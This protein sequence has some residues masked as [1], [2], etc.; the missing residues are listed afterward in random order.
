M[1][2]QN[3]L[4]IRL[5]E[6]M[7]RDSL[8]QDELGERLK[9]SQ[10]AISGLLRTV[11][12]TPKNLKSIC[13]RL[14]ADDGLDVLIGHLHD[15]IE[16]AGRSHSELSIRTTG[17]QCADE[18]QSDLDYLQSRIHEKPVAEAVSLISGLIRGDWMKKYYP[19]K[20]Q[21]PFGNA[22]ETKD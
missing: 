14:A 1:K 19:S 3:Q 17:A 4:G 20:T 9:L 10:G 15:E 13:T 5:A 8:R 12:P 18:A 22:A 21:Q 11:R 6:I 7:R 16:G 2:K